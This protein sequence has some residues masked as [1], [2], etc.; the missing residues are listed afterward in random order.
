MGEATSKKPNEERRWRWLPPAM[1]IL[2]GAMA[3]ATPHLPPILR[4]AWCVLLPAAA[5]KCGYYLYANYRETRKHGS[6]ASDSI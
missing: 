3:L 2:A 1:V 6:K 4:I 5:M